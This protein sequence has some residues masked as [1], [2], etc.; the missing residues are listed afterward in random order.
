MAESG[1]LHVLLGRHQEAEQEFRAAGAARP[2]L[3]APRSG[4]VALLKSQGRIAAAEAECRSAIAVRPDAWS[5]YNQLGAILFD[6]GRYEEAIEAFEHVVRLMPDDA[7]AL[8]N[9]GASWFRLGR[10][11]DAERAYRL[12]LDRHRTATA[13]TGL[14]TVLFYRDEMPAA[15]DAFERAAG[16]REND[17]V[18]WGNLGAALRWLP[19]AGVESRAAFDR[20]IALARERLELNPLDTALMGDLG[21]WLGQCGDLDAAREWIGRALESDPRSAHN[22]AHA[23]TVHELRGERAEALRSLERAVSLGYRWAEFDRDR[24]LVRLRATGDYR[25]LRERLAREEERS[26]SSTAEDGRS[27]GDS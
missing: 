14:G 22:H 13:L 15:V 20:A 27:R 17:P 8:A 23:V 16:L 9:I 21:S 7:R 10:L 12:S 4:L 5:F 24:D 18:M 11:D 25:A 1:Q 26:A 2:D 19:D 6:Q 3:V